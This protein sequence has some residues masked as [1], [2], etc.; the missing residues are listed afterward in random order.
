MLLGGING[1]YILNRGIFVDQSQS[2]NIHIEEDTTPAI[3]IGYLYKAWTLDVK[4]AM[5]YLRINMK[6]KGFVPGGGLNSIMNQNT[7]TTKKRKINDNNGGDD[8][9]GTTYRNGI[10]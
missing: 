9:N 5:Y 7:T 3:L 1:F 10:N 6:N 2:F 4:T 8:E